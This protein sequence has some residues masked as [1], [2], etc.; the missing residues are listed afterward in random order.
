MTSPRL[1]IAA[2]LIALLPLSGQAQPRDARARTLFSEGNQRYERGDFTGALVRFQ[3]AYKLWRNRRIL[4]NIALTQEKLDDLPG[5][6]ANYERFLMES[7]RHKHAKRRTLIQGKLMRLQGKLGRIRLTCKQDGALVE[8]DGKNMGLTPLPIHI[9]TKPGAHLLVVSRKGR[10][11]VQRR[12]RLGRG[13]LLALE[14][15]LAPGPPA[16]QPGPTSLPAPASRPVDTAHKVEPA[17]ISTPATAPTSMASHRTTAPRARDNGGLFVH[18]VAGPAFTN[19]GDPQLEAGVALEVG[20]RAGWRWRLG[21]LSLVADG[22]F[23]MV[24]GSE[25]VA[26]SED[27]FW[28]LS[29]HGGGG[30]RLH[31][32]DGLWAGVGFGAGVTVI[33]GVDSDISL[34]DP[35]VSV[36]GAIASFSLRPELT[37]GWRVWRGLTLVVVPLAISYSPRHEAYHPQVRHVLRFQ[38]ALGLG[39]SF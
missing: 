18:A 36:T 5:A 17:K 20:L 21:R 29:V 14:L 6:T 11:T 25:D 9:Y 15:D 2:L 4:L 26:G 1:F 3:E 16:T 33:G 35:R 8:L 13:Q 34:Y 32:L 37:L 23:S 12:L 22:S 28:F 38:V 27:Q 7:D 10:A 30:A 39:W 24:P 19:Y 31:I